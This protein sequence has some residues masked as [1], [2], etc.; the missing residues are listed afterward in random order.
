MKRN[1]IFTL[2][3]NICKECKNQEKK[4]LINRKNRQKK[5]QKKLGL[6]FVR[7]YDF[8]TIQFELLETFIVIKLVVSLNFE[9]IQTEDLFFIEDYNIMG[10][11][12]LEPLTLRLS[13][14]YSN[15]LSYLP[16][17]QTLRI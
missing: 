3:T 17:S 1:S 11:K 4:F 14:V 10:K 2:F 8:L 5:S 7:K 16:Y 15:L 6:N 12:G 13:S 9:K